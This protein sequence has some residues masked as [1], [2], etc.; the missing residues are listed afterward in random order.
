MKLKTLT[1][2][3]RHK[4]SKNR[5]S[6]NDDGFLPMTIHSSAEENEDEFKTSINQTQT[7][8]AVSFFKNRPR[9]EKERER[10]IETQNFNV[11][12]KT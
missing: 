7:V 9:R 5:K 2:D 8:H 6:K 12:Y 10:E 4:M 3:I 11:R 1:H